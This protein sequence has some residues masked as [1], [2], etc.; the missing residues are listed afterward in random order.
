MRDERD[1]G[2]AQ[3]GRDAPPAEPIRKLVRARRG[4]GD[5]RERREVNVE[6]S[7]ATK[8]WSQFSVCAMH[9]MGSP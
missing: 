5:Y 9:T 1:M 6:G 4:A 7:V 2:S 3:D 8:R